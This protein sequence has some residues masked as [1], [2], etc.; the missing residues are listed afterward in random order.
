MARSFAELLVDAR[1]QG[2]ALTLE[3]LRARLDASEPMV[4]LD[5]REGDEWRGGHLPGA[6]HLPR[7]HLESRIEALVPDRSTPLAV[8][9]AGG[10]RAALA[11]ATLRAMGYGSVVRVEPGFE[12]WAAQGWPV[13]V[14]RSLTEAQRSRYDRHLRLPEIGPTGQAALLDARVLLVGL[15]GLGSPVALYLAAAGVGT[16][17]LLDDDTVQASNLQRQ[18]IHGLGSLGRPKVDSAAEAIAGLNPDVVV[19]RLHTRLRANEAA[20]VLDGYDVIVDGSDNF[21]TRYLLNDAA[22]RAGKAL[23]HGSV[24]RFEGQ[25]TT[26]VPGGPCYRCLFPQ[27]PPPG[28]G[29]SC[30]EAGVLGV[31]PGVVGLLQATEVL[32]LL[33]GRGEALVGRMLLYDALSMDFR[34]MRYGRAPGCP[35]CGPDPRLAPTAPDEE[36]CAGPLR[37]AS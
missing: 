29:P 28:L 17:G 21:P 4:L 6:L 11:A 12:A 15:G 1:G 5:V 34:T 3:A 16:L 33:L 13:V 22:V 19:T 31:L 37:P 9:C 25:V 18:V 30:Q 7:G 23:V 27:P 10:T 35:T 8:Y 36:L 24:A 2:P 26:F 32:K 14:P 20:G